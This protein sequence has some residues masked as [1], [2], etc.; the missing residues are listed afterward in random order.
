MSSSKDNTRYYRFPS[1][2]SLLEFQEYN[3][4]Y[5]PEGRET[6]KHETLNNTNKTTCNSNVW[7]EISDESKYRNL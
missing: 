5:S 2:T 7:K 4:R 1:I 6:Q 3:Q